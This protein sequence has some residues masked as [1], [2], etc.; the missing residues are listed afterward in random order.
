MQ[1]YLK[2]SVP[3]RNTKIQ[4]NCAQWCNLLSGMCANVLSPSIHFYY[5]F[6]IRCQQEIGQCQMLPL[7]VQLLY[8]VN[9]R[10]ASGMGR[11]INFQ[12]YD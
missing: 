3:K 11:F 4:V 6:F 12:I 2:D 9:D 7:W 1:V 10:R 5:I 8:Q